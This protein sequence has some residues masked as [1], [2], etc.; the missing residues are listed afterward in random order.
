MRFHAPQRLAVDPLVWQ[1]PP[2][3]DFVRDYPWLS[4]PDWPSIDTLNDLLAGRSHA[5]TGLPLRF[6]EQT[7]LLLRDGLHYEQRSFESGAI[8][9]RADNWH[10]L[11]NALIW[12]RYTELKSAVNARYVD[13]L[14]RATPGER[15]RPQM[16]MTHF[17]ESGVIVLMRDAALITMWNAHDWF[18][19]F[20]TERAAWADGRIEVMVFGHALLEHA[21]LPYQLVTAKSILIE[22]LAG[23]WDEDWQSPACRH[24]ARELLAA[25]LLNDPQHQRPLPLSGIPGWHADNG[26]ADFYRSADC[27]RPLREGR[28]YPSPLQITQVV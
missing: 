21:L 4:G 12:V 14:R 11:L 7:P 6:V 18:Q 16:A 25:R 27:F 5:V 23:N 9:T 15:S 10:D 1:R 22:D 20:W 17:D 24:I 8:S 2:L 26:S 3:L 13:E 28:V 19:L